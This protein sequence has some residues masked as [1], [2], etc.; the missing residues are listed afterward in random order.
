MHSLRAGASVAAQLR[1]VA[2]EASTG[3]GV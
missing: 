3:A 1:T 2:V